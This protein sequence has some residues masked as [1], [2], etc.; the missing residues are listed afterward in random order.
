MWEKPVGADIEGP[1][2][3]TSVILDGGTSLDSFLLFF[4]RYFRSFVRRLRF[5]CWTF[6]GPMSEY[7]ILCL[8]NRPI[9]KI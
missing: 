5:G 8:R 1:A 7:R 6:G 3:D 2:G 4:S 9:L